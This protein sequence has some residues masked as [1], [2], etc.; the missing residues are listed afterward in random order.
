MVEGEE[1]FVVLDSVTARA[2]SS[3]WIRSQA[4]LPPMMRA[5]MGSRVRERR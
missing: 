1:G 5:K 3:R 2:T 4:E